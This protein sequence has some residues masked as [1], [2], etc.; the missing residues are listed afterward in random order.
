[1]REQDDRE[2]RCEALRVRAGADEPFDALP[3]TRHAGRRADGR[4]QQP[5]EVH[6][7]DEAMDLE[8]AIPGQRVERGSERGPAKEEE[9]APYPDEEHSA[10]SRV[11]AEARH[12]DDDAHEH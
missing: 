10:A 7:R 9:E 12:T 1:Q 8:I 11:P 4:E 3:R 5:T 6:T 2:R